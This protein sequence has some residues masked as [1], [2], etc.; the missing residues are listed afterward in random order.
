MKGVYALATVITIILLVI[1]AGRLYTSNADFNLGNPYANG[2]SKFYAGQDI[3][4]LYHLSDLPGG[5]TAGTT[6]LIV[7]PQ[8]K[9]RPGDS[10][11]INSYVKNGG[12]L[13]VAD[14]FGESDSL[15]AALDTS[16]RVRQ[17]SLRQNDPYYNT[18]ENPIISN[19]ISASITAG[20]SQLY[21]SHPASLDPGDNAMVL[22]YTSNNSW[23]DA[24]GNGIKDNG[25]SN[26]PFPVIARE[27]Y[28]AGSLT[29]IADPD[30]FM[31]SMIG[32][33]DNQKLVAGIFG[34][35]KVYLDLSHGSG[36]PMLMQA[37]NTVIENRIAQILLIAAILLITFVGYVM[38][39]RFY[40]GPV[41]GGMEGDL[42]IACEE[43][44]ISDFDDQV[45]PGQ[46]EEQ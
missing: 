20:V 27:S 35:N 45:R 33:G 15:L 30:L 3:T 23:R 39:R 21:L 9:Y 42:E 44:T 36:T 25:E 12:N 22:A 16:I 37:Y 31:N 28:G 34:G 6:L 43:L 32:K 2:F 18:P 19:I 7:D 1:V 4:Q 13:I 46:S 5:N 11:A 41:T 26:G 14:N 40:P 24:N 29:V 17:I 8:Y 10:A 38:V